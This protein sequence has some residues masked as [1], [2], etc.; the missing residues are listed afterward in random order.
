M[1]TNEQMWIKSRINK[2]LSGISP[3]GTNLYSSEDDHANY[4]DIFGNGTA[5]AG[6]V[7]HNLTRA[8]VMEPLG[9]DVTE[10]S[11]IDPFLRFIPTNGKVLT[12][13]VLEPKGYESSES[14]DVGAEDD[15]EVEIASEPNFFERNNILRAAVISLGAA[16]LSKSIESPKSVKYGAAFFAAGVAISTMLN[17][18]PEYRNRLSSMIER[19]LGE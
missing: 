3:I 5:Y 18:F 2:A 17:E 6:N 7:F 14:S 15:A 4:M 13:A 10:E 1:D 11:D 8:G 16:F 19:R 12:F 9:G